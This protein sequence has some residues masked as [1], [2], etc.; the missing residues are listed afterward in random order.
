MLM[1][2]VAY[3]VAELA[4]RFDSGVEVLTTSATQPTFGK[5]PHVGS[6]SALPESRAQAQW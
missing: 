1:K 5:Q 3:L 6:E 4:K 2:P